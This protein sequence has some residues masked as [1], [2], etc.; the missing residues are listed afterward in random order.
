VRPLVLVLLVAAL[1]GAACSG[2]DSQAQE[3]PG[4]RQ[5]T[6]T[7]PSPSLA[8][9]YTREELPKIALQPADRPRGLRYLKV[10]SGR[11]TLAQIGFV[12]DEQLKQVR[13]FGLRGIYD[14]TF[15]SKSGDLRLVERLWLFSAEKGAQSWLAK[16]EADSQAFGLTPITAPRIGE[17]SWAAR[18][19]LGADLITYAFR[20]G[21]VVAVTA[22]TAQREELSESEALAAA[23]KAAD[24]LRR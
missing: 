21:N 14:T 12:L 18:G 2:S 9:H 15:V 10:D 16:S 17:A 5:E 3:Q 6:A 11:R 7:Q 1:A 20:I 19:N 23:Q 13:G 8:P 24:R 22:Y 4:P